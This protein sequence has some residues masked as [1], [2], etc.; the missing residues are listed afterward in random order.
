MG[1]VQ[2]GLAIILR[3]RTMF[4]SKQNSTVEKS[5]P[6]RM[7]ISR[8]CWRWGV[9]GMSMAARQQDFCGLALGCGVGRATLLG[10]WQWQGNGVGRA[11]ALVRWCW[12][13][14][15]ATINIKWEG[16]GEHVKKGGRHGGGAREGVH[17]CNH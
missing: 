16:G 1:G 17:E 3:D 11:L 5:P 4:F 2:L 9:V 7:G 13:G 15:D 10:H 8:Q 6:S 12:R 14:R